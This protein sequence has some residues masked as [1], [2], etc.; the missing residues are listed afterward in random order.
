LAEAHPQ[1]QCEKCKQI[2][3]FENKEKHDKEDCEFRVIGRCKFCE[4]DLFLSSPP[5]F[6]FN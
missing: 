5:G 4:M 2:M 1:Y 6:F 3:D